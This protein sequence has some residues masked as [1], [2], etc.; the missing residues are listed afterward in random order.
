MVVIRPGGRGWGGERG[1]RREEEKADEAQELIEEGYKDGEG[2]DDEIYVM[3]EGPAGTVSP[4][5]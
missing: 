4:S 1:G 2:W 3:T 5:C